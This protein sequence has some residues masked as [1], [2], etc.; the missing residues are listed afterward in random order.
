MVAGTRKGSFLQT[1][2]DGKL[3]ESSPIVEGWIADKLRTVDPIVTVTIHDSN[4]DQCFVYIVRPNGDMLRIG[5][6]HELP[7]RK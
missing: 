5:T 7:H 6:G 1:Q 3:S 4:A 2:I